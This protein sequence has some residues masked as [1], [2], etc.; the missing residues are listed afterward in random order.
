[1]PE[2]I[3]R[4]RISGISVDNVDMKKALDFI[5]M[6]IKND[7]QRQYILAVNPE[8]VQALK[9]NNSLRK[10]F[11]AA[12]LLI[13]D[14]IGVVLAMRWL[15]GL[16]AKRVPGSEL[17]PNLC[18]LSAEKGYKIFIYG[19]TENVNKNV[20][21]KLKQEYP[22]IH[23]VGRCHGYIDDEDMSNLVQEI[24]RSGANIL[25]VALGSPSQELWIQKYL[26]ELNVNIC[27]GIGGT[28][29]AITGNVKRAPK[30]FKETGLEWFYRLIADP[31]RIRRQI[32]LPVFAMQ[33]VLEKLRKNKWLA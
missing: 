24:N 28:L 2:A 25:F 8:K 13:P 6:I 18:K 5:D 21:G 14:G 29:D 16:S 15:Y 31:R 22:D 3:K 11:D 32:V 23:I 4:V 9:R 26:P 20:V 1:M 30:L 7:K 27:Q 17:M 33:V 12:A 10:L 19:S